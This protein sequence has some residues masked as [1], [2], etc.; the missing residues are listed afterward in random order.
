VRGGLIKSSK[1]AQSLYTL[2]HLRSVGPSGG[3]KAPT[4]WTAR[5]WKH[6]YKR[7]KSVWK[8][9]KE[10]QTAGKENS[11]QQHPRGGDKILAET[12]CKGGRTNKGVDNVGPSWGGHQTCLQRGKRPAKS[13]KERKCALPSLGRGGD[14]RTKDGQLENNHH[15]VPRK[16]RKLGEG[17][18]YLES[19]WEGIKGRKDILKC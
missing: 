8:G 14:A 19:Y 12:L 5:G 2:G 6:I 18:D 13:L 9:G 11:T 3:R 10:G 17:G 15:S 7:V 1:Q 4:E 16:K